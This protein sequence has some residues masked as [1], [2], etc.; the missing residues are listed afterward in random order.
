MEQF[1]PELHACWDYIDTKYH[2][3]DVLGEKLHRVILQHSARASHHEMPYGLSVLANLLGCT[4]GAQTEIFAGT[5][6]PVVLGVFNVNYPQTRKSSGFMAGLKIGRALDEAVGEKAKEKVKQ[7]IRAKLEA[8]KQ[9]ARRQAGLPEPGREEADEPEIR[10]PKVK[11]ESSILTNFTEAA[12]FQRCSGDFPQVPP[13]ELYE[14]CGRL[15]YGTIVPLDECYKLMKIL[16]QIPAGKSQ[17]IHGQVSDAASEMNKLMQTGTTSMATKTAG[18]YGQGN[19]EPV[20]LGITGNL[21]PSLLVP[22]LRGSFGVDAVAVS[23]RLLFVTGRPIEPHAGLSK[24]LQVDSRSFKRW[25]WPQ[26]LPIMLEP[27]GLPGCS[28]RLDEAEVSLQ[29]AWENVEDDDS[30]D[31]GED[32]QHFRPNASGFNVSLVDGTETRIRF[33]LDGVTWRPQLRVANRDVPIDEGMQLKDMA[34]RVL[35]HFDESHQE[36]PWS[37]D[38]RLTMEGFKAVWN[39]LCAVARDKGDEDMAA[40]YGT[41]PW[42]QGMLAAAL[43]VGEIA[44]ADATIKA[45]GKAYIENSHILRAYDLLIVLHYLRQTCMQG[46]QVSSSEER[47]RQQARDNAA[48]RQAA[49]PRPGAALQGWAPF[50]PTQALPVEA[51]GVSDREEEQEAKVSEQAGAAASAS[52]EAEEHRAA[53]DQKFLMPTDAE[54]PGMDV[55]YGPEGASVQRGDILFSD[56][57]I[58]QKTILRGE[59][60]IFCDAACDSMRKKQDGNPRPTALKHHQWKEVMEQGLVQHRVGT[61]DSGENAVQKKGVARIHLELPGE[62]ED[63]Q[64][65]YHNRLMRLCGVSLQDVTAAAV[66]RSSKKRKRQPQGPQE[67]QRASGAP[68]AGG[69]AVLPALPEPAEAAMTDAALEAIHPPTPRSSQPGR[70]GTSQRQASRGATAA[71]AAAAASGTGRRAPGE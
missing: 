45:D 22:M 40:L 4:N 5:L 46:V 8:E 7:E 48:R 20:S 11:I 9:K 19:A 36:I 21:H 12:F 38:A 60:I 25:L 31:E 69:A 53:S 33:K 30:A 14:L 41:A 49:L 26:L 43:L 58:M 17:D 54:V 44:V 3:K 27:L 55:G 29:V 65:E 63:I 51:P 2:G 59:E 68:G 62:D 1:R 13:S 50:M 10:V 32:S 23:F 37:E 56:R 64:R 52:E 42:H 6:N 70:R 47:S 24:M 71:I 28:Q 18:S 35:K 67:V 34:G 16:G 15:M 61:Y 66:E 57:V 39:A